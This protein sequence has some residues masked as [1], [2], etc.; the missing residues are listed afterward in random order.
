MGRALPLG[1]VATFPESTVCSIPRFFFGFGEVLASV[2][3]CPM[4]GRDGTS[5]GIA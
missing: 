4:G 3:R 5:E 2:S 1:S